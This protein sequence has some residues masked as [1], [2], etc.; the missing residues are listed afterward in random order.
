MIP[1]QYNLIKNGNF[2]YPIDATRVLDNSADA[3]DLD[4]Y[5]YIRVK[6]VEGGALA[7]EKVSREKLSGETDFSIVARKTVGQ[8]GYLYVETDYIQVNSLSRYSFLY[9]IKTDVQTGGG[10]FG[11]RADIRKK[12]SEGNESSWSPS[13]STPP[14]STRTNSNWEIKGGIIGAHNDTLSPESLLFKLDE[15][16][17]FIKLRI[18][19]SSSG[20][21][22]L[23]QEKTCIKSMCLVEGNNPSQIFYPHMLD[24]DGDMFFNLI[25]NGCFNYPEN[26]LSLNDIHG[27]N[28]LLDSTYDDKVLLDKQNG[29]FGNNCIKIKDNSLVSKKIFETI[30]PIKVISGNNY[31]MAIWV[32][33]QNPSDGG[34][35]GTPGTIKFRIEKWDDESSFIDKSIL[36]EFDESESWAKF[37]VDIDNIPYKNIK[38][39]LNGVLPFGWYVFLDGLQ[40][41]EKPLGAFPFEE[42]DFLNHIE[43]SGIPILFPED[44]LFSNGYWEKMGF[45]KGI[46]G[47]TFPIVENEKFQISF[48]QKK[49]ANRSIRFKAETET[50]FSIEQY[51]TSPT[52]NPY[53]VSEKIPISPIDRFY[54][55]SITL[56]S[57]SPQKYHFS[58]K[59]YKENEFIK[60]TPLM[61]L[62]SLE[63]PYE[64]YKWTTYSFIFGEGTDLQFDPETNN[65]EIIF[66][67]T[68]SEANA[69][70]FIDN[71]CLEDLISP[72]V[73]KEIVFSEEQKENILPNGN[74]SIDDYNAEETYLK[75][76]SSPLKDGTTDIFSFN[77]SNKISGTRSLKFN[78]DNSFHDIYEIKTNPIEVNPSKYYKI[79]FYFKKFY[80][81]NIFFNFKIYESGGTITS[82]MNE[83]KSC[84]LDFEKWEFVEFIIGTGKSFSLSEGT[85]SIAI[86]LNAKTNETPFSIG[87]GFIL[88]DSIIVNEYSYDPSLEEMTYPQEKWNTNKY[89]NIFD[90]IFDI[91]ETSHAVSIDLFDKI[92]D[93]PSIYIN[94][95]TI[96]SLNNFQINKSNNYAFS[97]WIKP[98]FSDIQEQQITIKI[99]SDEEEVFLI[100][101][102]TFLSQSSWQQYVY[103]VGPSYA[104]QFSEDISN[105]KISISCTKKCRF[106]DFSIEEILI[107]NGHFEKESPPILFNESNYFST[108]HPI[109]PDDEYY[110]LEMETKNFHKY[111]LRCQDNS[112]NELLYHNIKIKPFGYYVFSLCFKTEGTSTIEC[113]LTDNT[114][115]SIY[116]IEEENSQTEYH[117]KTLSWIIGPDANKSF[118]ERSS[119]FDFSIKGNGIFW[120]DGIKMEEINDLKTIRPY[121]EKKC[122]D[123]SEGMHSWEIYPDNLLPEYNG[124]YTMMNVPK[125]KVTML[126]NAIEGDPVNVEYYFWTKPEPLISLLPP[127]THEKIMNCMTHSINFITPLPKGGIKSL[128]EN[129]IYKEELPNDFETREIKNKMILLTGRQL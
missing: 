57:Y 13:S 17:C 54:K 3:N 78:F 96:E 44:N 126:S 23:D 109:T 128:L 42:I 69:V 51:S 68:S 74:L 91:E 33:T 18:W 81:N 127:Y 70:V 79:S 108:K 116:L 11:I 49:Y 103:F 59:E 73:E 114:G 119:F 22:G 1:S 43:E 58:I 60:N 16:T 6:Y 9:K 98:E 82:L 62:T 5:N 113:K 97:V 123:C 67:A 25:Q 75:D 37:S 32:K 66:T 88:L 92:N 56:R 77:T 2:S 15:D 20:S 115:K 120:I 118:S 86:G 111:S 100:N 41:Y 24:C 28:Y 36:F 55:I 101:D 39:Y 125:V 35:P 85:E 76:F 124:K 4:F 104:I 99:I 26:A 50:P 27:I 47:L 14:I 117:W 106:G 12:D 48:T 102:E 107:P 46:N 8:T 84:P 34:T 7:P 52:T 72:P 80:E 53:I 90:G 87:D 45:L 94:G 129:N 121:V 10:G 64:N 38:I 63:E 122:I 93:T 61:S 112:E 30:A 89:K 95:T 31:Q 105:C 83:E 71:I 21:N 65:V 40:L 19:T 29:L 110:F